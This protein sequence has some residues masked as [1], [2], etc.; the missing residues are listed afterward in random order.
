MQ[1]GNLEVGVAFLIHLVG[2][3]FYVYVHVLDGTN[4]KRTGGKG[5][6]GAEVF[7]GR[8]KFLTYINLVSFSPNFLYIYSRTSLIRAVW[9][10]GMS[11]SQKCP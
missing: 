7:G 4:M 8:W 10:H 6:P 2:L 1:R 11:V 9:D 3:G 5:V